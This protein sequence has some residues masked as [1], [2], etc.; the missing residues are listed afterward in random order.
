MSTE[1][2]R[3]TLANPGGGSLTGKTYRLRASNTSF[4]MEC[5][6]G[7]IWFFGDQAYGEVAS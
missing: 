5:Q 6:Q 4:R 3:L 2:K 1:E 7:D